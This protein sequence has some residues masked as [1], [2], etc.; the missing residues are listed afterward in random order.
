LIDFVG[1]LENPGDGLN[2]GDHRS[3]TTT[4]SLL[5]TAVVVSSFAGCSIR[6]VVLLPLLWGEELARPLRES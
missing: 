5:H 2:A 4:R 6:R 1:L 3:N